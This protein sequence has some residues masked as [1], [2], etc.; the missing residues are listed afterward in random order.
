[1]LRPIKVYGSLARFIGRKVFH[2]DVASAAEAVRALIANFPGLEQ[3]MAKGYYR[4][5][6]G[7]YALQ[8][9]ELQDPAGQQEI[10]IVPVL[11]GASWFSNLFKSIGTILAGALLIG[12]AIFL[13]PAV[14]GLFGI[15]GAGLFSAS[16]AT[17]IAG[18]GASL[19]LSGIANLIS[20]A[21]TLPTSASDAS[22]SQDPRKSFYFNGIQQT[23]RQGVPIP[24]VYGETVVGSVVISSGIDTVQVTA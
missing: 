12:A 16:A 23:S 9:S 7:G 1:M 14:G 17:L 5:T 18:V 20:P 21:P 8:E 6:V 2:A 24:V 10:R 13:G 4:V 3:H 22:N 11:V 15:A 19:V